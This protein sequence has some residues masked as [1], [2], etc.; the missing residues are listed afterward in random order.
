M[1]TSELDD[2]GG[3]VVQLNLSSS[4]SDIT[5]YD[6]MGRDG[7]DVS[8]G[9]E[10]EEA[11]ETQ[12]RTSVYHKEATHMPHLAPRISNVKEVPS[13]DTEYGS[14]SH[15]HTATSSSC[16]TTT[17]STTDSKRRALPWRL[18][19]DMSSVALELHLFPSPFYPRPLV[20]LLCVGDE[21]NIVPLMCSALH[22]RRALGRADVPVVGIL[23]PGSGS[24]CEVLFG[25]VEKGPR[26]GRT[27]VGPFAPC[28]VA[29]VGNGVDDGYR[30]GSTSV[31]GACRQ[32]FRRSSI[33]NGRT[34]RCVSCGSSLG[35]VHRQTSCVLLPL[36]S[37]VFMRRE[38]RAGGRIHI[39]GRGYGRTAMSPRSGSGF[40]RMKSGV[41]SKSR[42]PCHSFDRHQRSS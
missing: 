26:P 34:A 16:S 31:R 28:V 27:L 5:L 42:R 21:Q 37:V 3:L 39:P 40:G 20:P 2:D 17:S 30:R 6:V 1:V 15:F 14:I 36:A 25:W 33:W 4:L 7:S 24:T 18:Y 29:M 11:S 9:V 23:L 38:I 41:A 13:I 10:I 32:G 35:S 12:K 8:I 19:E 22:Q